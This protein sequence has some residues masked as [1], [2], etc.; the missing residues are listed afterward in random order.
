MESALGLLRMHKN[1]S[2]DHFKNELDFCEIYQLR[3]HEYAGI[4]FAYSIIYISVSMTEDICTQTLYQ[5]NM[6]NVFWHCL[7]N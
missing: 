6:L 1:C 2:S 7:T 5:L 3:T 4:V